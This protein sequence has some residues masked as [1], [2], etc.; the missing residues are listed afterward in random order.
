MSSPRPADEGA[1]PW[2]S[3]AE[4]LGLTATV[5]RLR[6]Q[7]PVRRRLMSARGTLYGGA[8]LGA[9][10][11]ALERACDR[12]LVWATAQYLSFVRSSRTGVLDVDVEV[13]VAGAGTTQARCTIT[14]DG[15]EVLMALATLGHRDAVARGSWV[16]RPD[17]PPVTATRRQMIAGAVGT[18]HDLLD[19]RMV[20]GVS[21]R[22]LARGKEFSDTGGRAA[23]WVRLPGGRRTPDGADLAL[24]GDL[25]P[26]AF[27]SAT[28]QPI[29][30]FSLD[31]TIRVGELV[32][33]EWVLV[34]IHVHSIMNG[35]G[36]GIAH[37][38]SEDGTLLGTASQSAVVRAPG[39]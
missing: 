33:T 11:A 20:H 37:L 14:A 18:V 34:D 2:S 32:P 36:H 16:V 23:L 1:G 38:W 9:A 26:A 3:S 19:M 28:G 8:A 12:P 24:V 21:R 17:V 13:L 25:V 35:Y 5:D 7:V 10:I 31:N 22:Q 39:T 15:R 30:G 29:S 6:W 27:A 4:F